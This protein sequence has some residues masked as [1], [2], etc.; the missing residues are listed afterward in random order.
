[1]RTNSAKKVEGGTD[2]DAEAGESLRTHGDMASNRDY[3]PTE[4]WSELTTHGAKPP[5][6][7]SEGMPPHNENATEELPSV[8]QSP[9]LADLSDY[10]KRHQILYE[11]RVAQER[12]EEAERDKVSLRQADEEMARKFQQEEEKRLE[13]RMASDAELSRQLY[14]QLNNEAFRVQDDTAVLNDDDDVR[15]PMRTGYAERLVDDSPIFNMRNQSNRRLLG[16]GPPSSRSRWNPLRWFEDY[17][18][19]EEDRRTG[20]RFGSFLCTQRILAIYML[21]GTVFFATAV[22]VL[23]LRK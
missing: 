4:A 21:L 12:E 8:H 17:F 5:H 14:E 15:A 2:I 9:P 10:R 11:E 19:D 20:W 16:D 6:S 3:E 13:T 22:I 1:M 7:T 23:T 18:S